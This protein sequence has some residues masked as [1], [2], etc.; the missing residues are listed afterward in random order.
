MS[1]ENAKE[2]IVALA[3]LHNIAVDERDSLPSFFFTYCSNILIKAIVVK[4]VETNAKNGPYNSK[5]K[6]FSAI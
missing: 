4:N 6:H 1:L 5:T 2:V 3:V